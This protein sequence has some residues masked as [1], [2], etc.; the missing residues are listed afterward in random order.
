MLGGRAFSACIGSLLACVG[1]TFCSDNK[2]DRRDKIFT[3]ARFSTSA[4]TQQ[5][6]KNAKHKK[7]TQRLKY[8]L[9]Q[10]YSKAPISLTSSYPVI[11]L[12]NKI[13][14]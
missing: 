13:N 6:S 5:F 3:S 10:R 4:T 7:N 11:V 14:D 8:M 12:S 9:A 2:E 1:Q